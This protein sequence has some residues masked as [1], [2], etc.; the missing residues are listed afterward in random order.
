MPMSFYYNGNKVYRSFRCGC[1]YIL[2]SHVLTYYCCWNRLFFIVGENK[3]VVYWGQSISFFTSVFKRYRK[4]LVCW[5]LR[6][7]H[8]RNFKI[9]VLVFSN[10]I[11]I[12]S[13]IHAMTAWCMLDTCWIFQNKIS[14]GCKNFLLQHET[15]KMSE[16]VIVVIQY[17][18]W[19]LAIK[20]HPDLITLFQVQ[21]WLE[22][23]RTKLVINGVC[24]INPTLTDKSVREK[25]PNC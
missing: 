7:I 22:G 2:S 18:P 14:K 12:Y 6:K 15:R 3:I 11:C 1:N 13:F 16:V 17:H 25:Q 19:C 20:V 10:S 8:I 23:Q 4:L 9:F 21:R 24:P 5:R